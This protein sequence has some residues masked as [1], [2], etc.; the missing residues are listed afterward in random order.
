[1]RPCS[2]K[3]LPSYLEVRRV[4]KAF[5]AMAEEMGLS[6]RRKQL[7]QS[8]ILGFLC[9]CST[10]PPH[11]A[12]PDRIRPFLRTLRQHPQSEPSHE[13]QAT[14]ALNFLFDSVRPHLDKELSLFTTGISRSGTTAPPT[15]EIGVSKRDSDDWE[16]A[17]NESRRASTESES[18]PHRISEAEA[19]T[20]RLSLSREQVE[21]LQQV[22]GHL[23]LPPELVAQRAIELVCSEAGTPS[24]DPPSKERSLSTGTL[25]YQNQARIDL[26]SARE[27]SS[28]QTNKREN[29]TPEDDRGG[30]LLPGSE[31]TLTLFP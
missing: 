12:S 18:D 17:S 31:A 14:G 19:G 1:M 2:R 29:G 22:A 7:Y 30:D 23:E 4:L 28:S 13:A 3:V 25:L 9:W 10:H 8:W 11:R 16:G 26:F 5:H 24:G 6:R 20:L 27:S 15:R 21:R